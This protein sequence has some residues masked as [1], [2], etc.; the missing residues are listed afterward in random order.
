MK[1]PYR[2][3]ELSDQVCRH[4]GCEKKLKRNVVERK[5]Q[6]A[7]HCYKHEPQHRRSG[8]EQRER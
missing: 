2:Y 3:D 5:S 8:H 6:Y 7:T 1:K 4:P